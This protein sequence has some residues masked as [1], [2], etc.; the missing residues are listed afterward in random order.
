LKKCGLSHLTGQLDVEEQWSRILSGGEQ[1]RLAFARLIANSPDIVIMD[2][3]TSALDEL[4]QARMMDFLRNELATA[5]VISVGHRPGLELY[6][7]REI[8]LLR[9][10]RDKVAQAYHRAY[11]PLRLFWRK[12]TARS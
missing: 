1:Q 3:A 9:Q 4:S 8:N 2:E 10:D 7:T 6:H 5:T 11:G 12:L